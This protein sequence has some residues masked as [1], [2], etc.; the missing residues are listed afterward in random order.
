MSTHRK[1]IKHYN[2]PGHAHYLTFSTYRRIPLLNKDRTRLWLIESIERARKLHDFDLWG[3]VIMPDHAHL[4]ISPRQLV[5]RMDDILQS[6]KQPVSKKTIRYLSIQSPA[7]LPK[8]TVVNA[9]RTYR[10]FWQVGPGYD[11]N[12]VEPAATHQTIDYMHLNP[13]RANLVA[14]AT[15]WKWSSARDWAGL[16]EVI[17]RVDRNLPSWLP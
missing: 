7:F 3:W 14:L 4:L 16:D 15:E 8:L 1:T 10:H 13:V 11:A 17:M 9:R 5:Y 2:I 6:I 12:Q